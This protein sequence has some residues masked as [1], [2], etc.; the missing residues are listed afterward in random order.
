MT[1]TNG[2]GLYFGFLSVTAV[3]I[4]TLKSFI[5]MC[6]SSHKHFSI[7]G[8]LWMLKTMGF[9]WGR[10]WL[11]FS[12][13][14]VCKIVC[15]IYQTGRTWVVPVSGCR[16]QWTTNLDWSL[17]ALALCY[18]NEELP[19]KDT[20]S[21]R[22]SRVCGRNLWHNGTWRYQKIFNRKVYEYSTFVICIQTYTGMKVR[23]MSPIRIYFRINKQWE[24][25]W[26]LLKII[27]KLTAHTIPRYGIDNHLRSAVEFQKDT[28]IQRTF[29]LRKCSLSPRGF[30]QK[31]RIS[32]VFY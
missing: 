11:V 23:I 3:T 28:L 5:I 4:I 15:I 13:D 1:V 19:R 31:F 22:D 8:V 7:H 6:A 27:V 2:T 26:K 32:L 29:N 16:S 21:R 9:F 24:S 18:D 10:F 14:N 20:A 25:Y 30:I 17:L 12:K